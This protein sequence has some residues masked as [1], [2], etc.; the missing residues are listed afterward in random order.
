MQFVER[1]YA[2]STVAVRTQWGLSDPIEVHRGVRQGCPG[3][4]FAFN[5][6][7]NDILDLCLANGISIINASTGETLSASGL[8]FADDLALIAPTTETLRASLAAISLW[9]VHNEMEFGIKKCGVMG[10]GADGMAEV[11]ALAE[12]GM[13]KLSGM[14]LPVVT[15][16]K[17][18]GTRITS[19]LSLD[20]MVEERRKQGQKAYGC[21]RSFLGARHI[22]MSI[23]IQT[24]KSC[25]IPTL[26][27]GGE[28]FAG[29]KD[30]VRPLQAILN[31]AIKRVL[32]AKERAQIASG[33]L[34]LEADIPP[35]HATVSAQRC[36][37]I[38]KYPGL[39]TV[40]GKLSQFPQSGRGKRAWYAS[41]KRA[42][43]AV[44]K[45]GTG[46]MRHKQRR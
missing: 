12:A 8:L 5:V 40:I 35:I 43:T 14:D 11:R 41:A 44:F 38:T 39:R 6:F 7:I 18:L 27:F 37:A 9:A 33:A 21:M 23:R 16:Y 46:L 42:L 13:W 19:D 34:S 17:Y 15:E 20:A 26:T 22:P 2:K 28:L 32:G 4:P 24:L 3:S 29:C 45:L 30:R 31:R 25:L 36:R 10:I 1:L